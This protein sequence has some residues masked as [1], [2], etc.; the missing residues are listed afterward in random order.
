MAD[1]KVK[2]NI[3]NLDE[4]YEILNELKEAIDKL[5]NFKLEIERI[6]D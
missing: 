1:L 4:F 3:K 6:K 5:K 2:V